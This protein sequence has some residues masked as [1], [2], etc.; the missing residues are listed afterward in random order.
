MENLRQ[1]CDRYCNNLRT[2]LKIF[3]KSG[4]SGVKALHQSRCVIV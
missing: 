4:P 1:T 3:C 2:N